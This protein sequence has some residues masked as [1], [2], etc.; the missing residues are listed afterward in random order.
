MRLLQD[1][2]Y[3]RNGVS[4]AGFYV[5][6]FSDDEHGPMVGVVFDCDPFDEGPPPPLNRR[7]AVFQR[8]LLGAGVIT[9]GVNSF[10]GDNY[11]EWLRHAIT[12]HERARAE[13]EGILEPQEVET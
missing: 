6:T 5:V 12:L 8:D 10:R 4:G 13:A 3:H 9:F 11:D 2:A 7:T 1:I